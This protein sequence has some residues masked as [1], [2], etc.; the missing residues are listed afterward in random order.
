MNHNGLKDTIIVEWL[1]L[2]PDRLAAEVPVEMFSRPRSRQ[3]NDDGGVEIVKLPYVSWRA[4]EAYSE[5][6]YQAFAGYKGSH[7]TDLGGYAYLEDWQEFLQ[8]LRKARE[9]AADP[10]WNA[11]R[12]GVVY[13]CWV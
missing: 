7:T 8:S 13:R 12:D 4:V 5:R 2:D 3:E 6:V 10:L 1:D 9:I 11:P